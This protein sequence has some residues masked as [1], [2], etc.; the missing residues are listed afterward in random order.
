M[1]AG[2]LANEPEAMKELMKVVPIGQLG[3]PEEIHRPFFDCEA[4][5]QAS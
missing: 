5:A 4:R 2:M 3:R 1:I